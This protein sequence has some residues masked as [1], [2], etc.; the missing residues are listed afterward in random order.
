VGGGRLPISG[1]GWALAK[2]MVSR[3]SGLGGFS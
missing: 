2:V 3:G 1:G